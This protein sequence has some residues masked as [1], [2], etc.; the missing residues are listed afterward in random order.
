ML[1]YPDIVPV[2]EL[3]SRSALVLIPP[4][5]FAAGLW[6]VWRSRAAAR[7]GLPLTIPVEIWRAGLAQLGIV[8]GAVWAEHV[9]D[10]LLADFAEDPP[11]T[12]GEALARIREA[13]EHLCAAGHGLLT[14][15]SYAIYGLRLLR[16]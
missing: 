5:T 14:L 16:R 10:R 6:V 4:G 11:T 15:L 8:H 7:V 1:L 9:P 2:S 12:M 13:H 3:P